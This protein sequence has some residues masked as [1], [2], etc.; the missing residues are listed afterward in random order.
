MAYYFYPADIEQKAVH[1]E[2]NGK[3]PE[4][5]EVKELTEIVFEKKRS[6][7]ARKKRH[8]GTLSNL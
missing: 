5:E 2:V 1:F 7:G 6:A 8:G 3:R 4:A